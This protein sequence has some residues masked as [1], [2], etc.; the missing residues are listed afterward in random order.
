VNAT[1]DFLMTVTKGQLLAA[2]C[3]ILGVE[4]LTSTL[5]LPSGISKCSYSEQYEYVRGIATAMVE[6]RTLVDESFIGGEVDDQNDQVHN[7]AKVLCH[8]G[9]LLMEFTDA[10]AEGDSERVYRC[11]RVSATFQSM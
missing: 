8:Y 11:W 6:K 1:T 9:L 2:A 4:K 7:Y 5:P 10:W 3:K